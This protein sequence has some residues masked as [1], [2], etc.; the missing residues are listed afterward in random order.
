[1]SENKKINKQPHRIEDQRNRSNKNLLKSIVVTG[2]GAAALMGGAAA[3]G[4]SSQANP[5]MVKH[6]QTAEMVDQQGLTETVTMTTE[7]P[8]LDK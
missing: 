2:L 1:M 7:S 8:T 5:N 6:T 3:I 4:K